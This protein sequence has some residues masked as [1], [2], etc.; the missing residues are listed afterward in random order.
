MSCT[1]LIPWLVC[2]TFAGQTLSWVLTLTPIFVQN[3]VHFQTQFEASIDLLVFLGCFGFF[4]CF[5]QDLPLAV[6]TMI[7]QRLLI[8]RKNV[9]FN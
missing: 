2:E 6:R 1:Y 3:H 4:I 5:S 9:E 8:D 7:E